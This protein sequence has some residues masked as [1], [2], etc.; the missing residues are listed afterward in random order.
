M[1]GCRGDPLHLIVDSFGKIVMDVW[2]V[3]R[4][5]TAALQAS[6]ETRIRR[7]QNREARVEAAFLYEGSIDRLAYERQRDA[8]REAIALASIELEEA[9]AD[10]VDVEALLRFSEAVL[11]DSARLS[12]DAPPERKRS[13][14]WALFPRGLR[15]RDGAF[16]TVTTSLVF[17]YFGEQ[18]RYG[19][20]NGGCA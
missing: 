15:V 19:V 18:F 12:L 6:L 9:T 16:G 2:T 13:V 7:L 11:T 20:P 17:N 1:Y 10:D 4:Q 8:L 5:E 3:K 14:Q